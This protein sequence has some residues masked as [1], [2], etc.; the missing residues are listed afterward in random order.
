MILGTSAFVYKATPFIKT[1]CSLDGTADDI[2][3]KIPSIFVSKSAFT[4][5]D[6]FEK[7]VIDYLLD[8]K[9]ISSLDVDIITIVKSPIHTD[10]SFVNAL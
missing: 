4:S 9:I 8:N 3:K 1:G 2:T 7:V 10:V 6:E 5:D